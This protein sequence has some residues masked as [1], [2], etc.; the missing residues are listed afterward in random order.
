MVD[1][2]FYKCST[3]HSPTVESQVF[4]KDLHSIK[5]DLEIS[6][7]ERQ[8]GQI[9]ERKPFISRVFREAMRASPVLALCGLC[10][11]S[12]HSYSRTLEL[13]AHGS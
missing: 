8:T 1:L 12:E 2:E 5:S 4:G 11:D 6:P 9:K 13:P 7:K 10:K 3:L